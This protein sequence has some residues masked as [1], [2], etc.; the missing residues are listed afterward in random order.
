M[1][2]MLQTLYDLGARRVLVTGTGPLGCVPAEIAQRGRNGNCAKELQTAASLFNPKLVGLI[3][4]L[5]NK[6]GSNVFT[7]INSLQIHMDFISNPQAFG[8]NSQLINIQIF[9]T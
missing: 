8:N 7:V 5:N 3:N 1:L 9:Q 6:I 4:Q 2:N